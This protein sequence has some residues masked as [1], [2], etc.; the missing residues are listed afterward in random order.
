MRVP[1]PGAAR[2]EPPPQPPTWNQGRLQQDLQAAVEAFIAERMRE[3]EDGHTGYLTAFDSA[4]A[5][6]ERLFDA[7]R[8]LLAWTPGFLRETPGLVEPAR[9]LAA[10]PISKDDLNTLSRGEIAEAVAPDPAV[11]AEAARV[12][13]AFWDPRRF[14][15]MTQGR[16]PMPA[17][18]GAAIDW[19][20]GLMAVERVRTTRR[21]EAA[22][23]QQ[24]AVRNA[25]QTAGLVLDT[26]T[27]PI[28]APDRMALYSFRAKECTAGRDGATAK[29]DVPIRLRDGRLLLIECKVS[30]SS[31]NSYKRLL[32][33]TGQKADRWAQSFG[34]LAITAAVLSGVYRLENLQTAQTREHPIALFWAHNLDVLQQFV[35]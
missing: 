1:R 15:W 28:T 22:A 10:P 32:H 16:E 3:G 18:R 6:V 2:Q 13:R 4:R 26:N 5:S 14:P 23:E 35:R 33:E 21:N 8:S 19:T 27:G 11:A 25:L 12:I 7:T 24:E 17:E 30:N 9:F 31:V 20:A 34:G 29:C